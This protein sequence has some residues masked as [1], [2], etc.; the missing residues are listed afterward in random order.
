MGRGP[1]GWQAALLTGRHGDPGVISIYPVLCA[2]STAAAAAR[3][4]IAV[5]YKRVRLSPA[6]A[7][8]LGAAQPAG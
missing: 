7:R 6:A 5:N 8:G 1:R 2:P 3:A 4:S